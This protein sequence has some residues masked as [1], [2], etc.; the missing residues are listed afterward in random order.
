MK[1]TSAR[2]WFY[3][4]ILPIFSFQATAHAGSSASLDPVNLIQKSPFIRLALRG[5]KAEQGVQCKIAKDESGD[6]AIQ[7]YEQDGKSQFVAIYACTSPLPIV[8]RGVVGD[9]GIQTTQF[10][11]EAAN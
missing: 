10:G 11:Y 6:V 3:L 5:L 2:A 1:H 7:I 8:V 4:A 9:G